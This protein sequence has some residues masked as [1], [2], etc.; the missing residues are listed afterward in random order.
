[1][2]SP[3]T[4]P[5]NP[6]TPPAAEPSTLSGEAFAQGSE[7]G[8]Q[9]A[10]GVAPAMF[11]DLIGVFGQRVV[12]VPQGVSLPSQFRRI[13]GN[14]AAVVAPLPLHASYKIMEGESPRPENRAYVTYTFYDNVDRLFPTGPAGTSNL[15]RET[16]GLE[17]T[18]DGGDTS[19]GLRLPF[20]QL[21]GNNDVEDN[22]VGDLTIIYKHA[23]VNDRQTGDLFSGGIAI[24]TPTGQALEIDG[25][26]TIHSTVFQPFLGYFYN[27]DSFYLEGF[28]SV[29]VPTDMRDVALMFNSV[30]LGYRLYQDDNT[31]ASVRAILPQLE[32]HLNTPLNHRGLG[33]GPINFDDA[34]DLTGGCRVLFQRAE[35]G[36]AVGTPVT[37]PKPYDVEC[38]AN[39]TFH[40]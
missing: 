21:T 11:G 24:T 14:K 34:L 36:A 7:A 39:L 8:T 35:I 12:V 9:A 37:G 31:D 38:A 16:L 25:E 30:A 33:S 4:P 23:F 26:S 10:G 20:L 19:I 22:E 3:T 27:F 5:T 1:V 15:H 6:T 28:S 18:F 13:N 29:A 40:W 2:T 32:L 17:Q